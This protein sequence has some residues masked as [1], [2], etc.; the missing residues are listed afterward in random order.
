MAKRGLQFL[1][2]RGV[3]EVSPLGAS[4]ELGVGDILRLNRERRGLELQSVANQ[5]RIR[6]AYLEAIEDGRYKDLPGS[7]YAVGFVRS[8]ADYLGLDGADIVRRFREEVARIHGRTRLIF[9][10]I[11][12]EG[13]IPPA[14]ILL[15][16]VIGIGIGYGT[17]YY[18]S[19]TDQADIATVQEVPD[20]LINAPEAE[21]A[22]SAGS[23]QSGAAA[24]APSS[25]NTAPPPAATPEAASTA[26]TAEPQTA[27]ESPSDGEGATTGSTLSTIMAPEPLP[28]ATDGGSLE[29]D[30]VPPESASPETTPPAATAADGGAITQPPAA[31]A[32]ESSVS[33]PATAAAPSGSDAPAAPAGA[34]GITPPPTPGS[35]ATATASAPAAPTA[36][37]APE[38]APAAQTGSVIPS[39][40]TL[41]AAPETTDDAAPQVAAAPVTATRIRINARLDTWIKIT[42][43]NGRTVFNRVLN[44]GEGYD[45]PGE[46]GLKMITGNAGG[47]DI[48]VDG[49][50]IAPLG[51]PGKVRRDVEL[52][53]DKLKAGTAI[54]Q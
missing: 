34:E 14:A 25:S 29:T 35:D 40:P 5:L 16:S 36:P 3:T 13:T 22:P 50:A 7:T 45:V 10:A 20:R 46:P 24:E 2:Q 21:V 17:W 42:D 53:P 37:A 39:A 38:L 47:M 33:A 8:Y 26:P 23:N 54:P 1:P 30:L 43:H 44:A 18:L 12:A 19:S 31:P 27:T 6:L 15:L 9:P 41:P 11:T 51:E 48:L 4:I 28:S 52:D 49:A 32:A